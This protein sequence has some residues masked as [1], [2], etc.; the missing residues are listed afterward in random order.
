M[1]YSNATFHV[2]LLEIEGAETTRSHKIV[3]PPITLE[4]ARRDAFSCLRIDWPAWKAQNLQRLEDHS[5]SEE[6]T[7]P[8]AAGQPDLR[9]SAISQVW[10][11]SFPPVQLEYG[12]ESEQ[13][14]ACKQF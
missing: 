11:T 1:D 9:P 10:R 3:S 2:R 8:K 13:S 5:R 7:T 12:G 4:T 14:L 6:L